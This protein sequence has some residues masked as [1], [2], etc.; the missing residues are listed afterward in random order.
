MVVAQE[1]LLD[2]G[3]FNKAMMLLSVCLCSRTFAN[4]LFCAIDSA[5]ECPSHF[6][7]CWRP[8]TLGKE[9]ST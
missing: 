5:L 3:P 8:H 6:S 2:F 4:D 1:G 9:S 7:L